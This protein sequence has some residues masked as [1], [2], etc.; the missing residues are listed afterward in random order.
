MESQQVTRRTLL[1]GTPVAFGSVIAGSGAP[2][3]AAPTTTSALAATPAASPRDYGAVGDGVADDTAAVNACL[4]ANRGVDFGGPESTYLVTGTLLVAQAAPQ[5]IS[6][7]GATVKAGAAVNLMRLRGA[8]HTVRGLV[9]DGNGQASGLAVIV[10]GSAAGSTVDRCSFTDIAGC[11]VSIQPGAHHTRVVGSVMRRCGHGS[12]V[13]SP[14]N[15]TVFVADAD[16][17]AVLDNQML[18]CDWGVYFRGDQESPGIRYYTCRGNTI[19]GSSPPPV[20]SQGISNRYARDSTIQGNTIVGFGDNCVD[21]W[22]CHRLTI[23]NNNTSGGRNGVFVG[24]APTGSITISGNTFHAPR[25]GGV[26]IDSSTGTALIIGVVVTGNT[27]VSPGEYGIQVSDAGSAQTTGITVANND[28]QIN[29]TA[30][31]GMLIENVEASRIIGNRIYRP[32]RE[33]ILLRG[34]DVIEVSGNL[35]QDAGTGSPNAYNALQITNSN[36]VVARDNTAYGTAK[37]AVDITGGAGMTVTGTR[38]RALGTGGVRNGGTNAV[39]AD[40]VPL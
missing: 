17:C 27:I 36:R 18:E 25:V 33:A 22:G 10:E 21:G 31:L 20:E 26:R 39:L 19:T 32:K 1:Y 24:D 15:C 38:W 9:F 3:A 40:N 35:L 30:P 13:A 2:A 34:V 37:Y 16:F 11:A 5:V 14:F 6:A 23:A 4:A 12:A 29:G 28:L 7:S 8:G